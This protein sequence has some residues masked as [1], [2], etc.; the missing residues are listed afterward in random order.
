MRTKLTS[1][2]DPPGNWRQCL[3]ISGRSRDTWLLVGL[4]I[5]GCIW[6]SVIF[7]ALAWR[8]G[9]WGVVSVP[10]VAWV[11]GLGTAIRRWR[12]TS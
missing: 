7:I 8:T 6:V 11:G 2:S 1:R 9:N 3:R 4:M 10:V 5:I 12:K